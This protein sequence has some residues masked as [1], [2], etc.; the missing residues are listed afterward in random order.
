MQGRRIKSTWKALNIYLK[1]CFVSVIMC[2]HGV[3]P[4]AHFIDYV[5]RTMRIHHILNIQ[6]MIVMFKKSWMSR[7]TLMM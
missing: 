1:K 7:L 3:N 2:I 4:C 5:P 6:M